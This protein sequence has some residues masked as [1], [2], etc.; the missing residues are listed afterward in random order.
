LTCQSVFGAP[1]PGS[2]TF[3]STP[4]PATIH[5]YGGNSTSAATVDLS[6]A[7]LGFGNPDTT[8]AGDGGIKASVEAYYYD[9][10]GTGA[11]MDFYVSTNGTTLTKAMRLSETGGMQITRT[12]VTA[13]ADTDG[14]VFSGTYTPTLANTTNITSSTPFT[15]QYMRVG[16]VVTVSGRVTIDP[17]AVGSITMGLSLPIASTIV[18]QQQCCGTSSNQQGDSVAVVG[19]A[20]N[21]RASFIGVV[22]DAASRTYTYNFTYLVV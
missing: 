14:N 10:G 8:G 22:A 20:T 15:S 2:I 13:P 4:I 7:R 5:I 16:N 21:L 11:G 17:T 18:S 3:T 1:T 6:F 12:A 19:D 9:A